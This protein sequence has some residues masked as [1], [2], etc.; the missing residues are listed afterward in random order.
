MCSKGPRQEMKA[1]LMLAATSMRRQGESNSR[2]TYNWAC[3]FDVP[4]GSEKAV[5]EF[6]SHYAYL[7]E[8]SY[9]PK[10]SPQL[11][12]QKLKS[13]LLLTLFS[14]YY[15]TWDW[16]KCHGHASLLRLTDSWSQL[17]II[18]CLKSI[19]KL[20]VSFLCL[21]QSITQLQSREIAH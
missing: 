10:G 16:M 7:N 18:K 5:W 12:R 19:F 6:A 3:V 2:P 14:E 20:Y 8:E 1:K 9:V 4:F 15:S 13:Y 17:L 21:R 11:A